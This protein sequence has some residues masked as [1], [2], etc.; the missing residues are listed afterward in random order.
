MV[1]KTHRCTTKMVGRPPGLVA[2]AGENREGSRPLPTHWSSGPTWQAH[3]H[4]HYED[5]TLN[6]R[7]EVGSNNFGRLTR[8][9]RG[10]HA[11]TRHHKLRIWQ[12]CVY[13]AAVY[14]LDASGLTPLGAKRL[15]AQLIRQIRLIVR[16]PVYMTG[17]S[18][19]QVLE[20]WSLLHPIEAL[21][22]Q[23]NKETSSPS[24]HSDVFKRGPESQAWQHSICCLSHRSSRSSPTPTNLV[25]RARNAASTSTRARHFLATCQNN[26]RITRLGL[27]TSRSASSTNTPTHWEDCHAAATATSNYTISQAFASTSMNT[28]A[29]CCFPHSPSRKPLR[30]HTRTHT[31]LLRVTRRQPL[32]PLIGLPH[33]P[34][35]PHI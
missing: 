32:Q 26:I 35:I 31:R 15:T 8:I 29:G 28:D 21:Q 13:T 25:S 1:P 10:R 19:T 30:H 34:L 9:L 33:N 4:D 11:L 17:T 22:R 16:D 12:A 5:R 20:K 24:T 14:G 3:L 27:S 18:H 7:L 2:Q 6:H 23:L